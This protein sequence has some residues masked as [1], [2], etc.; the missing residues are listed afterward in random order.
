VI[1]K[2]AAAARATE[3]FEERSNMG[4]SMLMPEGVVIN[5]R[6]GDMTPH[7]C[8]YVK[9][10]SDLRGIYR[11]ADAL[12]AAIARGGD[13]VAYQVVEYRKPESDLFFGTTTMA[14]GKVQDEYYM[15]R[16]HFHLRRE[17]AEVYYTQ[18]GAGIL[19]LESAE[20]ESRTIAMQPGSCVFV[21][22]HW[23]HRSINVGVDQLVFMWVC[24]VDAGHDYGEILRRGMR[25]I[26]IDREGVPTAVDNSSWNM[27]E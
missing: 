15:T 4:D 12:E 6:T 24:S 21:A 10:L 13:P 19:L 25:K 23:A 20:G 26:V 7:T 14:P 3:T 18:H 5:G 16:G 2:I 11:D 1:F 8:R 9:R 22:P 27:A 17:M